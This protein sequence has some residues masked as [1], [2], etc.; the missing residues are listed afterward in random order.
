M[1]FQGAVTNNFLKHVGC[2]GTGVL[3]DHDNKV[4]RACPIFMF[5]NHPRTRPGPKF[6]SNWLVDNCSKR[7]WN[8]F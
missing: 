7:K 6:S 4:S 1:L 5:S 8:Q 3:Q 2:M